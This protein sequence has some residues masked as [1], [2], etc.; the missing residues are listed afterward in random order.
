MNPKCNLVAERVALGEPL[1]DL[2]DHTKTCERCKL[3]LALPAKLSATGH[4]ADPG[5]GFAS[6]VHAGAQ[7]RVVVR[8]RQRYAAGAAS[9]LAAAAMVTVFFVHQNREPDSVAF[10]PD[11]Y[12]PKL[13]AT[14][15]NQNKVSEHDPWKL[16]DPSEVDDD[17][18]ALVHLANTDHSRHVSAH[19]GR[20]EKSLRPYKAVLKGSLEP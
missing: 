18:R 19:W 7:H 12:M 11:E 10:L 1:D 17:V 3:T 9:M 5:M 13:P 8:R 16:H 4:A 15:P 2:T 20:I 14:D 6:R